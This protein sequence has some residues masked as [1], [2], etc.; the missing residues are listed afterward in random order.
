MLIVFG[1]L[2]CILITAAKG[3]AA[4]SDGVV[5]VWVTEKRDAK[6][7]IFNCG[8][9][10]CGKIVW[11]DEPDYKAGDKEG[12]PGERKLDV[13]NP[14]PELRDR[15]IL[16]MQILRDFSYAGE[17]HWTGGRVYDPETGNTYRARLTLTARNQLDLR[18][19]IFI[20]LLGRTSTWTRVND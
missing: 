5:G 9:K 4:E 10:Y 12:K 13:R 14:D 15:V 1:A 8:D 16:G 19:Y 6:I 20:P 2:L 3:W 17:N 11:M 18:G 7:E